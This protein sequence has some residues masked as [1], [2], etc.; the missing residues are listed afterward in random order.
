VIWFRFPLFLST[1]EYDK[2]QK[3][4]ESDEEE[5]KACEKEEGSEKTATTSNHDCKSRNA[6]LAA[7]YKSVAAFYYETGKLLLLPLSFR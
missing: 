3:K 4:L 2:I 1:K 5:W 7:Y 6:D